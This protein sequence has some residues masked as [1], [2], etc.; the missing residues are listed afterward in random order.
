MAQKQS[1]KQ[2]QSVKVVVN[3]RMCCDDKKKRRRPRRK[4][5]QPEVNPESVMN[6]LVSNVIMNTR[7]R[8]Y[9]AVSSPTAYPVRPT[10][11][12][13]VSQMI[14]PEYGLNQVPSYF[15]KQFTNQQATLE[16]MR[17][18]INEIQSQNI[19]S[20]P[21]LGLDTPPTTVADLNE[22][23]LPLVSQDPAKA[24]PSRPP[25]NP[26]DLRR[27]FRTLSNLLGEY[28]TT[29]IT[30]RKNEVKGMMRE[31]LNKYGIDTTDRK[32]Y[33]KRVAQVERMVNELP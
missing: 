21:L 13:P 8:G 12:A 6:D 4:E 2:S 7:T 10:V 14:Q 26:D 30:A 32:T 31:L 1:N 5:A 17:R 3:N 23:S 15:D 11:Y 19:F 16:E 22:A 24:G 33:A 27:D 20:N 9:G 28:G 25:V 29:E 18:Q